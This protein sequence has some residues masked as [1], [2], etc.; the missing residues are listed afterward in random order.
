MKQQSYQLDNT[1]SKTKE[2][3][4]LW[5]SEKGLVEIT[6]D[7]LAA[8]I[9]LD[10]QQRG[11]VFQG[12]GRLAV[13]TIVETEEGAFGNPV[14]KALDTPFLMLGRLEEPN[15]H[16]DAANA[17]DFTKLGYEDQQQ[18]ISK[19]EELLD[20]FFENSECGHNRSRT[21]I[22]NEGFVFAFPNDSKLDILV[23]KDSKIVYT[24]TDEVFVSKEDKVVLT[25][26]GDIAI[27]KPGK[28]FFITNG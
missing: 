5:K 22:T 11:Y 3:T 25:R 21:H 16:L 4:I 2:D 23:A 20:Q 10:G 1:V 27:S 7:T 17:E 6:K 15:L 28:S 26:H 9:I 8:K 18:F 24:T 12:S 19:A 14:E 13:D